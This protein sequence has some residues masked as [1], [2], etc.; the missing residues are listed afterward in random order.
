MAVVLNHPTA[1]GKVNIFLQK[2][3]KKNLN[4]EDDVIFTTE[5]DGRSFITTVKLNC[6]DGQEFK[7]SKCKNQKEAEEEASQKILDHYK[8]E[9]KV[10]EENN[11]EEKMKKKEEKNAKSAAKRKRPEGEENKA[12]ERPP[13]VRKER[14]PPPEL[15]KNLPESLGQVASNKEA[16]N[17]LAIKVLFNN[18]KN[19]D[20]KMQKDQV[21]YDTKKVETGGHQST[22]SIPSLPGEYESM[23]FTGVVSATKKDAENSAAGFALGTLLEDKDVKE[24][25]S[26]PRACQ[27]KR[28]EK[29]KEG[30]KGKGKGKKSNRRGKGNAGSFDANAMQQ[31]MGMQMMGMQMMAMQMGMNSVW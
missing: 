29:A 14:A 11:E 28:A 18:V 23:G 15:V 13:K 7:S 19:D 8:D 12:E 6:M 4:K 20:E 31:M 22:V 27:M 17:A 30:G 2:H 25:L 16:L 3:L 9:I 26:A 21:L 5:K 24:K 10:I 1:K